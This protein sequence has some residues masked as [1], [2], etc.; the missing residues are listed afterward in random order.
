VVS[1]LFLQAI[2]ETN[3]GV[4][5]V[6]A[7]HPTS[8]PLIMEIWDSHTNLIGSAKLYLNITGVEQMFRYTNFNSFISGEP[9]TADARLS[10][11]EVPNEPDTNDKNF[12]FLHG[13]NVNPTQSR[14]TFAEVYKRMYWSGSHAKFYGVAWDGST[15]QPLG[16]G[17]ITPDLQTNIV[18]A[19]RT[20]PLLKGFLDTLNG[21]VVVAAHSLA[22]VVCLS[23]L[24]DSAAHMDKFFMMDTAAAVEA[25]QGSAAQST[26]MVHPDWAVYTNDLWASEWHS[27]F[28]TND[29]RSRLTW[30]DRFSN[31]P[32]TNIYNFYSSGEEVLREHVGLP[33]DS[34]TETVVDELHWMLT[35]EPLG[36]YTWALQEKTKGRAAVN[37]VLSSTHGGWRFNDESYGTN[38][39]TAPGFYW[40]MSPSMAA[41]LTT[42]QLMTNAFF[43]FT[44]SPE[45][46]ADDLALYGPGASD[47]ARTNQ[48][49]ILS[50][51]IPALTLPVGANPIPVLQTIG[52]N[53]NMNSSDFQNS[54]PDERYALP[55]G[56][57]WHHS[58]FK[59]VAYVFTYKLYY[60]YVDL[61]DLK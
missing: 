17:K 7:R 38:L 51:A 37:F 26:N 14:G 5:L 39:I 2:A 12:V 20:A 8:S 42:N 53:F 47:Y 24:N 9:Q 34:L 54:W 35:Q 16:L 32:L 29:S 40:H 18:N 3:G 15:T 60:K 57:K 59:A 41:L 31:L 49:R 1:G 46:N 4:V 61:G 10:D 27:F 45:D 19:F 50:D 36:V 33:P 48:N 13:Y 23:A 52:H 30:R 58:D 21:P 43:D 44:T 55:D 25:I 56:S 11:A 22:N 6:E 28:P